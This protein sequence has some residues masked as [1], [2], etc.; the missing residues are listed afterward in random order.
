M[1]DRGT[2]RT[3][4]LGLALLCACAENEVTRPKIEPP[5]ACG[6]LVVATT[7]Y[8]SGSIA[9]VDADSSFRVAADVTAIHSDAVVRCFGNAVYVVNRS[10]GDNIQV[11]DPAAGFATIRQ[12]SVGPGSN[13]QDIA[14]LT[15][16]RAYVSRLGSTQLLE[17]D[18]ST[19]AVRAEISLVVFADPDGTPDMAGLVYEE[20][21]L[22]V[23]I[24]RLDYG[25]GTYLPVPPS[26][27][28]VLD[29]RTNQ[30]VDV[31]ASSAG[32]QGIVLQGLNPIALHRQQSTGTLLVACAG[33]YGTLDGGIERVD[34]AGNRSLGWMVREADL[35]GDLIE[36]ADVE[37]S[38]G[39]VTVSNSLGLTSLLA[40]DRGTGAVVD[41]LHASSG[42]HLSDVAATPCGS[43]VVCDRNPVAPGLRVFDAES[44]NPVPGLSQPISTGLP[45]FDLEWLGTAAP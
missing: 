9:I 42:Y 32:V 25:G 18:P 15:E 7:D 43:V 12:F 29:T 20:P 4:C 8:Q 11:L 6:R 36:F 41:T 22:Y 34:L 16:E 5:P 23:A 28:A 27:L 1:I 31:D 3:L 35:G 2:V 24:Q 45:P 14:V 10:G 40:F 39:Y 30:L 37:G 17:V 38:R 33:V 13:P 19:G 21:F 26:M 44:G